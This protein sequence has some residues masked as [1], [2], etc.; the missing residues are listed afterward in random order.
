M[1]LCDE[2]LMRFRSLRRIRERELVAKSFQIYASYFIF[3]LIKSSAFSSSVKSSKKQSLNP[4]RRKEKSRHDT[5]EKGI[6]FQA[7]WTPE[8]NGKNGTS[9]GA[10]NCRTELGKGR[11]YRKKGQLNLEVRGGGELNVE[12]SFLFLFSFFLLGGLKFWSSKDFWVFRACL[13]N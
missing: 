12:A 6:S 9:L 5:R 8:E 11:N 1:T 3:S 10:K 13:W 7:C 4:R 2:D